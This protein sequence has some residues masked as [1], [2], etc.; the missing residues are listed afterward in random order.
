M[1]EKHLK[2]GYLEAFDEEEQLHHVISD[3][4]LASAS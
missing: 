3:L 2:L 1:V 4:A